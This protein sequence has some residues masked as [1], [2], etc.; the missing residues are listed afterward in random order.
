M[1]R[2]E[3]KVVFT[4][5]ERIIITDKSGNEIHMDTTGRNIYVTAP[6]TSIPKSLFR[7]MPCEILAVELVKQEF[8]FNH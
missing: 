2:C 1:T 7:W 5:D 8:W 4:E 3:H 6:E